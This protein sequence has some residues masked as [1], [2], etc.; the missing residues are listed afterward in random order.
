MG[1]SKNRNNFRKSF[2]Q[3]EKEEGTI[4]FHDLLYDVYKDKQNDNTYTHYKSFELTNQKF[5]SLLND[6]NVFKI[7]A[8]SFHTQL[9]DFIKNRE[10]EKQIDIEL[11][12]IEKNLIRL[13]NE[14][15]I[16]LD[17]ENNVKKDAERAQSLMNLQEQRKPSFFFFKKLF[18]TK[19]FQKW[20]LEAEEIIGNLKSIQVNLNDLKQQLENNE[21][22]TKMLLNRK[23]EHKS[24]MSQLKSFF[25]SYQKLQN[26][27]IQNY[28]IDTNN[29]FDIDF[30]EKDL[31]NIHLLNPY[32]SPKIAKL[33]SDI[34]LI[35]LQLHRD[36]I[37]SNAKNVK[38]NLNAYF[39]MTA[40]WVKVD[41]AISHNLWDTFFLCVPVVYTTLASASRLFPNRSQKQI[42]WLLIDEAGQA[43]PQSATGLI[44]RSKRCVI[45]GDPL[46]VEPVVTTPEK[47]VTKL[48]NEHNVTVNWSPYRASVQQLA[49]RV[50]LSGTYMNV[51]NT[52]EKIWTG[53]PLRTHRRCDDPMFSIANKIAYN[54]QMVK[55]L[56]TNSE[57]V[58]I[59]NSCW[60]DLNTDVVSLINKH[61]I[62]EEII[63]LSH[64]I[65]ELRNIGYDGI[66]YVISPFKSIA[67]YCTNTFR[68]DKKISCGTIHTFQGKETDIVFLVL[69][70]DPKSQGAR[71]WA[72]MKPNMLNVALTRAKKRFYVIGNKKLWGSCNYFN[73]MI[74]MLD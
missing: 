58:F 2:W 25:T 53:F 14:K 67:S 66:I 5:K 51:G 72:S 9:P 8:S 10:Q 23:N 17:K 44:H 26:E 37:L 73:T 68:G 38:N 56:T 6:F 35:A 39:E 11:K 16:L 22:K 69:G 62:K 21:K 30:Y 54:N 65:N 42:G 1:N 27:L 59:G 33:R 7:A 41:E 64:K 18:N 49:D 4:S 43:T 63:F 46:Q 32:H 31:T 50:S 36:A 74:K 47:L 34:F 29:I 71:N 55:A 24:K 15:G 60:F 45:V 20:N 40:G 52:D 3:T 48:R 12:E 28:D 13:C 57:E 19:S 70:S 61:V